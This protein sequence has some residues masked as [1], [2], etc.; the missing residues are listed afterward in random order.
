M[1]INSS[2]NFQQRCA[3]CRAAAKTRAGPLFLKHA[4]SRPATVFLRTPS[5]CS[6]HIKPSQCQW[7]GL[8]RANSTSSSHFVASAAKELLVDK[9]ASILTKQNV[10]SN[11][12][13]N[14]GIIVKF[15]SIFNS[16][17]SKL[18]LHFLHFIPFYSHF[19]IL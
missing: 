8:H 2:I 5:Q 16:F 9:I 3:A 17:I 1:F 13:E 11:F 19:S 10:W 12:S 6:F 4:P 14:S 7:L 18:I 15:Y